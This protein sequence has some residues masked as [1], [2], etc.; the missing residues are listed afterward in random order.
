[1]FKVV[2][3]NFNQDQEPIN[4]P[5]RM[6]VGD[7]CVINC[8]G[9]YSTVFAGNNCTLNGRYN[10][11]LYG[12]ANCDLS[13]GEHGV[14]SGGVGSRYMGKEGTIFVAEWWDKYTRK[15]ITATVGRD[16]ILPDHWYTLVDGK[17]VEVK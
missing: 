6:V 16:G 5:E 12:G 14:L 11:K 3:D 10:C 8:K 2:G 15:I 9:N 4:A 1:M 17:F 7:G 13:C